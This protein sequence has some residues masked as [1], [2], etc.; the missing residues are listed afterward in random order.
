MV[1][2][3][4]C[5]VARMPCTQL[6]VVETP[7][8]SSDLHTANCFN[9]LLILSV[10]RQLDAWLLHRS[11]AEITVSNACLSFSSWALSWSGAPM[12]GFWR[13]HVA[14]HSALAVKYLYQ[15]QNPCSACRNIPAIQLQRKGL[16]AACCSIRATA[17]LF[18]HLCHNYVPVWREDRPRNLVAVNRSSKSLPVEIQHRNVCKKA[19]WWRSLYKCKMAHWNLPRASQPFWW[20]DIKGRVSHSI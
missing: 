20:P 17:F 14:W 13:P 15:R 3:W 4:N 8:C 10:S 5:N 6:R 16:W 1:T 18:Q 7:S 11:S 2:T 12:L 19:S 9:S